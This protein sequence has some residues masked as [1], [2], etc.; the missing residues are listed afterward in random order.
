M[1]VVASPGRPRSAAKAVLLWT[2]LLLL[3]PTLAVL[4]VFLYWEFRLSRAAHDLA[5]L[6][7]SDPGHEQAWERLR[8][9]GCRS[10]PHL[11]RALDP[12]RD[13]ER[14]RAVAGLFCHLVIE[15]GVNE[16]VFNHLDASRPIPWTPREETARRC[17]V[18]KSWWRDHGVEYHQWW[19]IWS[20]ECRNP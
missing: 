11:V 18:F 17:D 15:F 13:P 20:S 9:A 8:T 14:L 7:T 3:L 16:D 6:P 2:S 5:T 1:P 19:R 12:S 10:L 4:S